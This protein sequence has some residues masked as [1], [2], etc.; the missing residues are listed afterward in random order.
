[1]SEDGTDR[2]SEFDIGLL[3][4]KLCRGMLYLVGGKLEIDGMFCAGFVFRVEFAI[5]VEF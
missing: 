5:G 2:W 4:H 3:E 1:M